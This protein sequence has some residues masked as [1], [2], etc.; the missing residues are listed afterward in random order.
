MSQS[1]LPLTYWPYVFPTILFLINRMPTPTL[2]FN[3]P[4]K[5]QTK[6]DYS[7]FG[8]RLRHWVELGRERDLRGK[9]D[10]NSTTLIMFTKTTKSTSHPSGE[11]K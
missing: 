8:R 1:P 5:V 10:Y 3:N 7:R 9:L 4:L 11:V 6:L 2:Q